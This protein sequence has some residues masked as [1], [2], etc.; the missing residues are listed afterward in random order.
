M[1]VLVTGATGTIG[2]ALIRELLKR[3]DG[4]IALS[5][6]DRRAQPILGEE[7]KISVWPEPSSE[8]LPAEALTGADASHPPEPALAKMLP[9][10]RLGIGGPVAGGHQYA[11]GQALHR[12][13][14]LPVPAFALRLLYGQMSGMITTGPRLRPACLLSLGYRFRQ[15]QLGPALDDVLGRR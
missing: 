4:V 11:L 10:F 2:R 5:R 6:D 1:Q 12:P 3:G 9:F 13:A 7:V 14:V 8:D 15:P